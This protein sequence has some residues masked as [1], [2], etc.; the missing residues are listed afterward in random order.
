MLCRLKNPICAFNLIILFLGLGAAFIAGQPASP[1]PQKADVEL[2]SNPK[3]PVPPAGQ[4][5]RLVLKEELS[6]GV[7]EGDEKYMFGA[8][9]AFN[10]DHEGNFYVT[11]WDKMEILKYDPSGKYVRTIG[12]KGQGPGEFQNLSIARFDRDGTLYVTDLSS[13]RISFFDKDGTYLRQTPIPD[14]FEDLYI[15]AKGGYVSSRT[16]PAESDGGMAFKIIDGFFNDKFEL[17][18][19]FNARLSAYK[20]PSGRDA[21]SRAKFTAGI[22]SD[23]AF[24]PTPIH[25]V[26]AD[27]TIYFGYP[28]DYAIDV[29]SPEGRKVKTIRRAY[30]PIKV[31]DKDKDYFAVTRAKPFVTRTGG[32]AR[33]EDEVRDILK[34]IEYPE[35]KPAYQSLAVMEDGWLVVLV[36]FAAGDYSLFDIFDESGRYIGQFKTGIFPDYGRFFFFKNGK[37]YAVEADDEGYKS[38]KRFRYVIENY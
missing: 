5:K 8:N 21:T 6:I 34:Y 18:T 22:L 25:L 7:R 30:D 38:A 12:R 28:E 17:A 10:T 15:G 36:D 35:N 37:A 26:A 29:Y 24:R 16:I 31:N 13:Q 14:V 3:T 23:M 27:G 33:S 4:R 32:G 1:G 2:V 9:V 11:D 20:P 19:E